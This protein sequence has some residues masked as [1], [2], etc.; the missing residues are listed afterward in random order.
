MNKQ[1]LVEAVAKALDTSKAQA[2][3]TVDVFFGDSGVI[4]GALKKGGEV[5]ITGFGSF[6]VRKRAARQ[7]RN[8]QTGKTITIKA[9]KAPVFKA[10][11]GLKDLVNK[12]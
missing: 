11:K 2:A 6:K 1:E 12:K 3:M 10:G 7:G 5:N 4:A 8:P 9:S